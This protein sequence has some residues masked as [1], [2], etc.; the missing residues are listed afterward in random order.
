ML[1]LCK[2]Q[3]TLVHASTHRLIPGAAIIFIPLKCV[4]PTE[5]RYLQA[6]FKS[7]P[8]E[9][10]LSDRHQSYMHLMR[11]LARATKSV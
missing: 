6:G 3:D 11:T 4:P 8:L 5:I 7:A 1:L 2:Q 10:R 9:V